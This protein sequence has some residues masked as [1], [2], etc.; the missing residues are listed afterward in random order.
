M[1]I[2]PDLQ[3]RLRKQTQQATTRTLRQRHYRLTRTIERYQATLSVI[4]AELVVRG[5]EPDRYRC[6]PRRVIAGLRH[7]E[8]AGVCIAILREAGGHVRLSEIVGAV[9][10]RKGYDRSDMALMAKADAGRYGAIQPT[11]RYPADGSSHLKTGSVG[12]DPARF[13][14]ASGR[15]PP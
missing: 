8:I 9:A 12:T 6:C 5:I 3:A 10:R 11:G 7:G 15:I 2:S 13:A 14:V 4:G 1:A